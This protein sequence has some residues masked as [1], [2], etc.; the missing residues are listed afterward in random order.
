MHRRSDRSGFGHV[1]EQS[2]ASSICSSAAW[3]R[4]GRRDPGQLTEGAPLDFWRIEAVEP[5]HLL[6]LRAEMKLPGRAWLQ[7]EVD[8]DTGGSTIRQT[9]IFDPVGLPGAAYWYGLFPLHSWLFAGM[10][11]GIAAAAA[12]AARQ[13][14]SGSTTTVVKGH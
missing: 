6:R 4:R 3:G 9:A 8:G 1:L 7:F 10:L 12:S 2:A 11:R 5:D 13:K 14:P